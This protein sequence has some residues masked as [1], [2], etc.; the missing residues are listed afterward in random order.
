VA[1]NHIFAFMML[2]LSPTAWQKQAIRNHR[3]IPFG[4]WSLQFFVG[5][6]ANPKKEEPW[7]IWG[8]LFFFFGLKGALIL[9]FDPGEWVLKE[10]MRKWWWKLVV[11][12]MHM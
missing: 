5:A 1:T 9:A 2:C 10:E 11:V 6:Q 8:S 4:L 3:N 12:M 7:R